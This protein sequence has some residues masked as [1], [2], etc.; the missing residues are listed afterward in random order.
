MSNFKTQVA[1]HALSDSEVNELM[2]KGVLSP[3]FKEVVMTPYGDGYIARR[4]SPGA[5]GA[6]LSYCKGTAGVWDSFYV[7]DFYLV[8]CLSNLSDKGLKKT[9]S[10]YESIYSKPDSLV[11]VPLKYVEYIKYDFTSNITL[12]PEY[13]EME[14][15]KNP[16]KG[17]IIG[18]VIAGPTG[19]IVGAVANSGTERKTVQTRSYI[20]TD[21]Y[22]LAIK[23][24][25]CDLYVIHDFIEQDNS[26]SERGEKTGQNIYSTNWTVK[27]MIENAK[28]VSDEDIEKMAKKSNHEIEKE[29][30][31]TNIKVAIGL[32][33]MIVIIAEIFFIFSNL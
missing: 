16:T 22:D 14:V 20:N 15:K 29:N 27:K 19:A 5:V 21:Y 9:S 33:A 11:V 10:G 24:Q 26:I 2:R 13:K 31:K 7:T 28:N 23:I 4:K 30:I 1:A 3:K 18:G 17:A 12:L 25:D 6:K 8:C 32:I